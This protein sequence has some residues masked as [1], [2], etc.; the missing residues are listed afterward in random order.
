[1]NMKVV[2][3]QLVFWVYL[4]Q[5]LTDKHEGDK[6]DTHESDNTQTSEWQQFHEL[7]IHETMIIKNIEKIH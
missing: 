2:Y 7:K 1:M 5:M 6:F 4:L 3:W